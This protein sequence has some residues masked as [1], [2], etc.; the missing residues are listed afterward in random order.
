MNILTTFLRL[1][2]YTIPYGEESY[3]YKYLPK[4]IQMD[5]WGN[6]FIK[7]GESRTMFTC[8]LDVVCSKIEKVNHVIGSRFIKTDGTTIL[9]ADDKAGMTVLL[10]MIENKVPGLYYF[11]I[12]EEIGGIGSGDASYKGDWNNY[13]RCISFDRKGYTSVITEQFYGECC[14]TEFAD[15]L[16]KA[17]N[18]TTSLFKFK[19]DNTGSF[20]D[21]ASFMDYIPECTNISVGYFNQHNK[22]EYQDIRFLDLLCQAVVKIDWESLPTKRDP[23]DPY[24]KYP[25]NILSKVDLDGAADFI[26]EE[27]SY[28]RKTI[29]N[30]YIDDIEYLAE[31]SD[32]RINR[33][34]SMIEHYLVWS[35]EITDFKQVWWDGKEAYIEFYG[36]NSEGHSMEFYGSREDMIEMIEDLGEIPLTDLNLLGK[37]NEIPF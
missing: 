34:I 27:R 26:E 9:G 28:K 7:I 21:S 32:Q 14:S 6:Y 18:K 33:E 8:H 3:F 12:G 36:M 35:E 30:V 1:T 24:S 25:K 13:D 10:Y 31:V 17:L 11:F 22:D 29:L 20:T 2:E 16:S 37:T 5:D 15:E 19:P 4:G 23:N